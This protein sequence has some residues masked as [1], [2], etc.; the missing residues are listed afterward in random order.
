MS[1]AST[2]DIKQLSVS[3]NFWRY[4]IP[5][6]A[7]MLISG[8]YQVVDGIFVGHYVGFEGLAAINVSWPILAIIIGFGLLLGMGFGALLSISRGE[9]NPSRSQRI[10]TSAFYSSLVIG[11]LV[12]LFMLL[13]SDAMLAMQSVEGA[14]LGFA[15]QYLNIFAKGALITVLATALPLLIRND[16]QPNISTALMVIGA[17]MNIVL[18][19][20]FIAVLDQGLRGAALASVGAQ[21]VVALLGLSYFLSRRA[22]TPL[23]LDIR[24]LD[25][26]ASLSAYKLGASSLF[27]FLYFG[28]I[29]A[30]HNRLLL[31]YG[32]EIH[33]GA[34]AIVGYIATLYY[35][36]AEGIANGM[37]PPISYYHGEQSK[38]KI[39]ATFILALKVVVGVGLSC[40]LLINLFPDAAI[41]LFSHQDPL[42]AEKTLRGIRLHLLALFLDGFIFVNS[43]YFMA[44]DRAGKAM[45]LSIG[46]MLVQLPFLY[47]LPKLFGIDGVWLSVPSSNIVFCLL[48]SPMLYREYQRL[49]VP[50]T[51]F[52]DRAL[53]P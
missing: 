22:A 31:A 8:L 53:Q 42:L 38:E 43:I 36:F 4:V 14:S 23:K 12:V 48:I 19:Y 17:V 25:V 7:A 6:V 30:I 34:F 20:L 50:K 16:D 10:V 2:I 47:V 3:Q 21:A 39:K 52:F 27:M 49:S 40:Q 18:D 5:S 46:N 32:S 45:L 1:S 9:K 24:L 15:Q 13:A 28:F 51:A 29:L 26:R 11:V 44:I 33:V 35:L 41:G 37:Q